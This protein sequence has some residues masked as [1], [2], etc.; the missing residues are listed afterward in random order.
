MPVGKIPDRVKQAFIAAE[1]KNF[2]THSGIDYFGIIR[3]ILR[4]VNFIGSGRRPSGASTI[5]QQV[6]KNFCFLPKFLMCA[7]SEEAFAV[8]AD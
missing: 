6:A 5:T 7:K 8:L 2:Y 1:D 4:N 3:A